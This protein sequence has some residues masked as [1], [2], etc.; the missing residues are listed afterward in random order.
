[1]DKHGDLYDKHFL[2]DCDEQTAVLKAHLLI[3]ELLR[4]FCYESVRFPKHLQQARLSFSQVIHLTRAL[5]V[6]QEPSFDFMWGMLSQLNKLR[7]FMAHELE[8]DATK[9]TACRDALCKAATANR[10]ASN[11]PAMDLSGSLSYLCGALSAMLQVSL[12]IQFPER[13]AGLTSQAEQELP[14]N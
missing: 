11:S 3:E 6:L 14:S 9:S 7:N 2:P 12:A 4:D 13:F 1:M 10:I 5:C 8:P